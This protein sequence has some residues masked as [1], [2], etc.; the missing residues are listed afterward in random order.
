MLVVLYITISAVTGFASQGA[1]WGNDAH[2]SGFDL[3]RRL[4]CDHRLPRNPGVGYSLLSQVMNEPNSIR[5][6]PITTELREAH[7]DLQCVRQRVR[8]ERVDA[9]RW[10]LAEGAALEA[11]ARRL[12]PLIAADHPSRT[13]SSSDAVNRVSALREATV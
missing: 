1:N 10:R 6:I 5:V 3:F 4:R 7:R 13:S 2:V 12:K 8:S 11:F 9:W